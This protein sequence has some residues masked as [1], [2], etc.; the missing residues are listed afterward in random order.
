MADDVKR[1]GRGGYLVAAMLVAVGLVPFLAAVVPAM[2]AVGL[3]VEGLERV[4]VDG[5]ESAGVFSAERP[6]RVFIHYEPISRVDDTTYV[7]EP[8]WEPELKLWK[9]RGL[10]GV[11]GGTSEEI[12]PLE[13]TANTVVYRVG[14]Y[15]GHSLYEAQLPEEGSYAVTV[16]DMGMAGDVA[17]GTIGPAPFRSRVL[18]IGDVPVGLLKDGLLGVYGGAV[19]LGLLSCAAA[20]LALITWA[21]RHGT[22][23]ER[24]DGR[25]TAWDAPRTVD[26]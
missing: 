5:P 7:T 26:A 17:A 10:F 3:A 1:P 19:V 18:A 25:P 15:A 21:R 4:V 11:V 14:G 8:S 12:A 20:I 2:R 9:L 16:A 13:P 22:K 6:G 24:I 23:T